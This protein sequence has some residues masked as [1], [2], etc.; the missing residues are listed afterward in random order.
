MQNIKELIVTYSSGS[1]TQGNCLRGEPGFNTPK[2][3]EVVL[4]GI[5]ALKF[6][7]SCSPFDSYNY[8]LEKDVLRIRVG[9]YTEQQTPFPADL[10]CA[11][12]AENGIDWYS[13]RN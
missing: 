1:G 3:R 6:L 12:I 4:K 5:D 11:Y 10:I 2:R 8:R 13:I 9:L 7:N